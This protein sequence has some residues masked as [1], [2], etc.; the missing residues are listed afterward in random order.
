MF[1]G[2]ATTSW[3]YWR[4][5]PLYRRKHTPFKENL[6]RNPWLRSSQAPG[7]SQFY[8]LITGHRSKLSAK[9]PS[10]YL[11]ISTAL[12]EKFLCAMVVVK[13]ETHKWSKCQEVTVGGSATVGHLYHYSLPKA[14]RASQKRGWRDGESQSSGKTKG[15]VW[16]GQDP[17]TLL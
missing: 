8:Y 5:G 14:Q 15:S 6:A 1:W 17:R 13:V 7:V 16:T 9:F 4:E 3:H 11:Q 12:I 10:L 2:Q